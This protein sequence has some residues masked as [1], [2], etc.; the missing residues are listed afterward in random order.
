MSRAPFCWQMRSAR[1]N[2]VCLGHG[3]DAEVAFVHGASDLSSTVPV[4]RGCADCNP[5]ESGL[6]RVHGMYFQRVPSRL[7]KYW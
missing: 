7:A 2:A 5:W 6:R 3:A 4:I 1:C